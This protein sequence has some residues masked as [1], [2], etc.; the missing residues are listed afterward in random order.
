MWRAFVLNWASWKTSS[1]ILRNLT[2]PIRLAYAV[3]LAKYAVACDEEASAHYRVTITQSRKSRIYI[4]GF[5]QGLT[6][7]EIPEWFIDGW[8]CE[9]ACDAV[10]K[11]LVCDSVQVGTFGKSESVDA[12]K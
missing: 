7:L 2:I 5:L 8:F 10:V 12:S 11:G 3:D 4:A 6:T 9:P 1:Q